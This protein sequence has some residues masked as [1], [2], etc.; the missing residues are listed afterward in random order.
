MDSDT[1]L[2]DIAIAEG[3]NIALD[4][5]PELRNQEDEDGLIRVPD[6][7]ENCLNGFSYQDHY[8]IYDLPLTRYSRLTQHCFQSGFQNLDLRFLV[9][10]DRLGDPSKRRG[11]DELERWDGVEHI[12]RIRG[13]DEISI[14]SV[15]GGKSYCE[16]KLLD[17]TD[18]LFHKQDG[19]WH[20]QIEELLP[21]EGIEP[22]FSITYRDT[23]YNYW[24]RYLHARTNEELTECY[25]IDGAIRVYG[26]E[27]S[28]IQRHAEQLQAGKKFKS[29]TERM[30]LFR[31]ESDSQPLPSF[32][33]LI[34]F[35]FKQN[36]YVKE[37][38]EGK[39]DE[40]AELEEQ[41]SYLLESSLGA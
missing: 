11:V 31:I 17:K 38:F 12:D 39:S 30:K 25:H 26:D 32:Y 28:F 3:Q 5:Y 7:A 22:D 8:L 2:D 9:D 24:T 19:Y 14:T 29:E 10:Y 23:S 1:W 21:M 35:F 13:S 15:H 6:A 18:F 41:R 34:G 20:F 33:E 16:N 4:E 40:S 27:S 37:F 36:P